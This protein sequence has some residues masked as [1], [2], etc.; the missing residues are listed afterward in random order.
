MLH[1]F[2]NINAK[3]TRELQYAKETTELQYAIIFFSSALHFYILVAKT[4]SMKQQKLNIE[5]CNS[6]IL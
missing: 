2:L 6:K 1:N 4:S 5:N 3:E